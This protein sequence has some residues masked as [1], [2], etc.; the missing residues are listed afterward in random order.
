MTFE[1]HPVKV[2]YPDRKL[3]RIFD[4]ED[5][6]E[7]LQEL[8]V[9]C[10]LVEPFSREFSQLPPERYLL[11][12]I[13]R[14][15]QPETLV[16][17]YDFSFGANRQGSIEFLKKQAEQLRFQIEVIP[18]QRVGDVLVSSTRIR[19]A[20][21]DGDVDL[22]KHLLGRAFY[23][24]GLVEKG[25]GRG[26]QIGIP[27]ANLRASAE[28]IPARGVYAGWAEVRGQTYKAL[29]NV[30]L[31][32]TFVESSQQ[33]LS[34]EAHL[35]EFGGGAVYGET[36]RLEFVARLRDEEKFTSVDELVN[37]IKRDIEMGVK[38]LDAEMG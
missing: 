38:V 22:A 26:S 8:G 35:P 20:L 23:I 11:E 33:T 17:G 18:P 37:Q 25:A 15:F 32:P 12:W 5:Q 13:F 27:T 9:D 1:P 6:R 24:K 19:T 28:V 34:I 36:I 10:L 7:Q 4:F 16:V 14:P 31:N 21:L 3:Q 29:I 30:G 2:L